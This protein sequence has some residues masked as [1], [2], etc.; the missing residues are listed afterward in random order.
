MGAEYV[1]GWEERPKLADMHVWIWGHCGGLGL[2][3][4]LVWV[5]GDIHLGDIHLSNLLQLKV[6]SWNRQHQHQLGLTQT[7]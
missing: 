5:S 2:L 6:W 1:S 3:G 7:C 4:S